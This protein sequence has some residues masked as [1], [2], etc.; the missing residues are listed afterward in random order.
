MY[1]PAFTPDDAKSTVKLP[2]ATI[3]LLVVELTVILL[4]LDSNPIDVIVPPPPLPPVL[5]EIVTLPLL[6]LRVIPVPA[7]KLVTPVLVIV[8]TP[9]LE[10]A[11]VDIPLP[12]VKVL[13]GLAQANN[14]LKLVLTLLNAT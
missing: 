10:L 3:G 5:A 14:V 6:P 1:E 13:Y 11:L 4:A 12:A 8:N 7:D 2:F 9:V